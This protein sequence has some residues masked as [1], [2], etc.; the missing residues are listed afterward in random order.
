MQ[1]SLRVRSARNAAKVWSSCPFCVFD[2]CARLRNPSDL[3]AC[4]FVRGVARDGSY[5]T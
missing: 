3:L 5:I 1:A 4:S 2:D